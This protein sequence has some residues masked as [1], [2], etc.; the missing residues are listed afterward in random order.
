MFEVLN[1]SV[2]F[3]ACMIIISI[4]LYAADSIPFIQLYRVYDYD[5]CTS[6]YCCSIPFI[7]MISC[8]YIV[9]VVCEL[10][11]VLISMQLY[12]DDSI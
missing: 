8:I 4:L 7:D 11:M 9:S 6:V 10:C 12:T 5:F 2:L 1:T 3:R